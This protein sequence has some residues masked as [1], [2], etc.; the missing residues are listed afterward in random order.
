MSLRGKF[1][2]LCFILLFTGNVYTLLADEPPQNESSVEVV[3]IGNSA[4]GVGITM[5]VYSPFHDEM[6]GIYGGAFTINGQY[7]LNMSSTID[8]LASVGLT[9]KE[10]NPYY[11]DPSFASGDRSSLR[12]IPIELSLRKRFSLMKYPPRGMFIGAGINYIVASEKMPNVMSSKGGDFGSHIFV[13]P[14]IFLRDGL[15]FE[16]EIK[17]LVNEV[18]MKSRNDRYPITFSGLTIKAG[19][20]WYY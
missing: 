10:G 9:R 1:L 2:I 15:A 7:S 8:L 12:I 18:D 14:Q 19:L 17:L 11:D 6:K 13:G 20:M 5:G 3:R 4:D 16:G